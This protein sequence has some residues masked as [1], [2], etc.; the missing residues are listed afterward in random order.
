MSLVWPR[1]GGVR[2]ILLF[3]IAAGAVVA[4][5]LACGDLGTPAF[6]GDEGGILFD[7]GTPEITPRDAGEEGGEAAIVQLQ[8]VV[9]DPTTGKP[10]GLALVAIEVGGLNQMNPGALGPDGGL[11]PTVKLDPFYRFGALAD[12]A[13]S[14][15]VTVPDETLGV[16]AYANGFYCGVPDAGA[17]Q[18]DAGK[19]VHVLPQPLPDGAASGRPTITDFTIAPDVVAPGDSVTLTAIVAAADP[20][21]DPLSE[22]VLAI[23]P[24]SGW[25]GAFAPP[26]PGTPAGGFANGVY[27]RLV[28]APLEPGEYTFYMVA[29]T[30]SCVVSE[31]V[32]QKLLVTPT[33]DG[34]FDAA[35]EAAI[36]SGPPE[37]GD[38]KGGDH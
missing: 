31:P 15:T 29:T 37:G 22:Q 17:I 20:E 34:G 19:V 12:E 33:G 23:E 35:E 16:H 2:A 32:M 25:A 14:F 28:T 3:A 36:E 4:S 6:E 7:V 21:H 13:G 38:V 10:L 9:L 27:G 8:G 26:K 11:V 5:P 30:R 24:T 18:A 1:R